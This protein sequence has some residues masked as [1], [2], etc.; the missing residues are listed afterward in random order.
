MKVAGLILAHHK[1]ESL[2]RLIE[3]IE[4]Y[5]W[6]SYVHL[7]AKSDLGNFISSTGNAV[8]LSERF[9]VHWGGWTVVHA[10]L[11]LM[12]EALE[13]EENTHFYLLSG[14]CYPIKSAE[15]MHARVASAKYGG[16][17]I[18]IRK[19]PT[20]DKPLTRLSR[21]SINAGNFPVNL[22]PLLNKVIRLL[23]PRRNV[24]KLL[25]GIE[26]CAGSQWWLLSRDSV[27]RIIDFV[28]ANPWFLE[29]FKYSHCADEIFF[30]TLFY[31]LGLQADEGCPTAS[32][33]SA[34][35]P[36]PSLIDEMLYLEITSDWHFMARK[37]DAYYPH[38]DSTTTGAKV[39]QRCPS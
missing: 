16:N 30:Q 13:V 6:N 25:R 22:P 10:T 34:G 24:G 17:F 37:F 26:P 5:G 33:W 20:R 3:V 21:W 27:D 36:S 1:P 28:D 8:L 32:K 7:D 35:A 11:G 38:S 31:H 18:T 4:E 14:Q 19:M 39:L 12:R 9:S 23:A 15:D 2:A 29:S